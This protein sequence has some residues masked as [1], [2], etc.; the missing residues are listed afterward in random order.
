VTDIIISLQRASWREIEFPVS[1]REYGFQHEQAQHRFIFRDDQLIESLGR[2]NPTYRYTIPFREDLAVPPW[3]G[4]HLFTR[5]YP[6]FLDACVDKSRGVLTDPAH[7]SRACKC[8]SFREILDVNRR[9][10]VDVE[11]EFIVSPAEVDFSDPLG[12]QVIRTL[13]G[14]ADEARRFDSAAS[15]ISDA[16]L[17]KLEKLR[18]GP[19]EATVNPLDFVSSVGNQVEVA[20]GKVSAALAD[21]AFRVEK[22]TDTIDRLK[23]PNLAQTRRQARRLQEALLAFEESTDPTGTRPLRKVTNTA[24]RTV[25]EVARLLGMTTQELIRLNPHLARSPL[26]KANTEI[27]V[28]ADTLAAPNGSQS[29]RS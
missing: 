29:A 14:A 28:F 4:A 2:Q 8:V 1:S 16:D 6:D 19:P 17:K 21:A 11:V 24:N 22:S 18:L 9:D 7:G 5:V 12:V 10:G 26:V 27:R 25:S 23:N 3:G 20:G 15:K 13:Q